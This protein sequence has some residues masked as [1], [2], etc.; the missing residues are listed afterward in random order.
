MKY[1]FMSHDVHSYEVYKPLPDMVSPPWQIPSPNLSPHPHPRSDQL[2]AEQDSEWIHISTYFRDGGTRELIMEYANTV[3]AD[4]ATFLF[5]YP[6]AEP[7]SLEMDLIGLHNPQG[8]ST[9]IYKTI[10]DS[11]DIELYNTVTNLNLDGR[12]LLH[13][14]GDGNEPIP[15]PAK[16][17]KRTQEPPR[18]EH[19]HIFCDHDE[20]SRNS[21]PPTFRRLYEWKHMDK[22]DRPY[23]CK[24]PGCET[25]HGF[26]YSGGLLRHQWEVHRKGTSARKP[27]FCVYPNCNRHSGAGF[28]RKEN[29]EEHI[30]R[31]HVGGVA[32]EFSKICRSSTVLGVRGSEIGSSDST[33]RFSLRPR[34]RRSRKW[35][36]PIRIGNRQIRAIPDTGSDINAM[37]IQLAQSLSGEIR[38]GSEDL[39]VITLANDVEVTSIGSIT[40]DCSFAED[41]GAVIAEEFHVFPGLAGGVQALMGRPFLDRTETM[42]RHRHRLRERAQGTGTL[43]RVMHTALQKRR[44]PCYVG[45]SFV[46]ANADTTGQHGR[47]PPFL[48]LM[49]GRRSPVLRVGQYGHEGNNL[50]CCAVKTPAWRRA[51][52]PRPRRG[53]TRRSED[54]G[55]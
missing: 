50:R 19:G 12:P 37:T 46:L 35:D 52:R 15:S 42:T 33:S 32:E 26:T 53:S 44:F 16:F 11:I 27:L 28:T 18:N 38:L 7:G 24:E 31:R 23:V 43:P 8:K 9:M 3:T 14:M 22:H 51:A 17:F 47:Y 30:R 49:A 55:G 36:L 54:V 10:Q 48:H 13:V 20:C 41:R 39:A 2:E 6:N 1:M 5:D 25:S 40:V 34:E 4:R 29:L 45:S 21:Q